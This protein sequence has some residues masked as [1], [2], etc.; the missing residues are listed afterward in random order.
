MPWILDTTQG[1]Q[2]GENSFDAD[3]LLNFNKELQ[4]TLVLL[5]KENE[6]MANK[7]EVI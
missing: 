2:T 6:A 7:M 5:K 3:N 1:A 4:W